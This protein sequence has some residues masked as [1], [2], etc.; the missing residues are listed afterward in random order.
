[1]VRHRAAAYV[2]TFLL[3]LATNKALVLSGT[4]SYSVWGWIWFAPLL[5]AD[6]KLK[7]A[8]RLARQRVIAAMEARHAETGAAG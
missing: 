6:S 7:Q 4:V 3:V 1:M 5:L 2:A 8:R